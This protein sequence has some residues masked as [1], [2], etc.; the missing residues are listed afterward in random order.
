MVDVLGQGVQGRIG[1][2][3]VVD[4]HRSHMGLLGKEDLRE[5]QQ[6][7][8]D[9]HQRQKEGRGAEGPAE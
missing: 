9:G 1:S 8:L 4:D 7:D 5:G 6:P 2:A 3:S